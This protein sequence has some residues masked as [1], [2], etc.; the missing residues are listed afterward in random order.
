MTEAPFVNPC[1]TCGK[2]CTSYLVDVTG[3]DLW[4]IATSQRLRPERFLRVYLQGKNAPRVLGCGLERDGELYAAALDKKG[5]WAAT[6]P[7]VFL[8]QLPGNNSRC[9]IYAAR[10]S[11]CRVYPMVQV[12]DLVTQREGTRCPENSWPEQ[13]QRRPAWRVALQRH[14]MDLELY[15]DVVERWNAHVAETRPGTVLT[16]HEYFSYVLN[17]YDEFARIETAFGEQ[18]MAAVEATWG[19]RPKP[20]AGERTVHVLEGQYPWLDYWVRAQEALARFYPD[21]GTRPKP[22]GGMRMAVLPAPR[23]DQERAAGAS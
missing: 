22:I 17:V 2:C 15:A 1:R 21:V 12:D 14:L 20:A 10:P 5:R 16:T 9:G 11:T 18:R 13:E 7:C 8:V 23:T 6:Q 3:Y 19:I 4:R